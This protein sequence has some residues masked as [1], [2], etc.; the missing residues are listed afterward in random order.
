M[1]FFP[2][3]A[4]PSH[5]NRVRSSIIRRELGVELLLH[6]ERIQ[7][8]WFKHVIRMPFSGG[9]LDSQG[10]EHKADSKLAG[11]IMFLLWPGNTLGPTRRSWRMSLG[12]RISG[13]FYVVV[14]F[15]PSGN[16]FQNTLYQH[17]CVYG[18]AFLNSGGGSLLVG[19]CN[20]GLVCGTNVS[21]NMEDEARLQVDNAVKTFQPP[22]LPCNYS[23]D[24][25]PV[26]RPGEET[27]ELKVLRLTFTLPEHLT[28]P[29]LFQVGPGNIYLRRDG[30]VQ[31]PL[32]VPFILQWFK[33]VRTKHHY[34]LVA[35]GSRQ[36]I[37][38][39]CVC[40]YSQKPLDRI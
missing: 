19:V 40:V 1:S 23:L 12:R 17:V 33:Q 9:C 7:L 16:Y 39:V 29:I 10:G 32:G 36:H 31:G 22:L 5:D 3:V 15:S 18:C 38:F 20:N 27:Q 37:V 13:D 8:R 6:F 2:R 21:H 14:F 26:I 34:S 4:W 24:F 11:G 30:S 35:M 28:E 25:L